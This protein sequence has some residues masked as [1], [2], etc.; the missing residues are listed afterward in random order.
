MDDSVQASRRAANKDFNARME[1]AG[2]MVQEG[3]GEAAGEQTG[4]TQLADTA[5]ILRGFGS[6]L[7][8]IPGANLAGMGVDAA[9]QVVQGLAPLAQGPVY[10]ED[11]AIAEG[12]GAAG[13]TLGTA[14]QVG[15][16]AKGIQDRYDASEKRR[17]EM[18]VASSPFDQPRSTPLA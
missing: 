17:K 12:L 8:L 5:A 4:A 6:L 1:A 16:I 10:G 18:G 7:Q 3:V 13:Q 14:A 2:L 9:G 15:G 11:P